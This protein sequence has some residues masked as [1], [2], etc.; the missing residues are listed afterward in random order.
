[1]STPYIIL[2]SK[3]SRDHQV[4][5]LIGLYLAWKSIRASTGCSY[6]H[7]F[8]DRNVLMLGDSTNKR[9][10]GGISINDEVFDCVKV[11]VLE[12]VQRRS[13]LANTRALQE[14]SVNVTAVADAKY[15][16][17]LNVVRFLIVD[18]K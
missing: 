14:N 8:P 9:A 13:R 2:F 17:Q 16:L 1:M 7:S 4:N 10:L 15:T 3:D 6:F 5:R 11:A 18:P 12:V